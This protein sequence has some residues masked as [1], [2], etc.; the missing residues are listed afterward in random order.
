M[1]SA[2]G[3]IA[4]L[5]MMQAPTCRTAS[6]RVEKVVASKVRELRGHEYCQFRLYNP[7]ADIDR[8]GQDDFLMVFS[9]EGVNGSMNATRQFLVAFPSKSSCQPSVV[10]VGRRGVRVVLE[11]VV[12]D[13]RV[14]LTTA[15]RKEGDALC[16]L[17]GSGKLVFRHER[18][19]LLASGEDVK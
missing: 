11:V 2:L 12:K 10:E 16:C 6:S 18:G 8:D 19:K 9:V 5:S 4:S 1:F 13:R 15:E 17:S 7:I 3:L 14:V